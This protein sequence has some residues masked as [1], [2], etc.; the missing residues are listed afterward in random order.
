MLL[1][2]AVPLTI[3]I[4]VASQGITQT[5][6]VVT[7][8]DVER[9]MK[10]LSNWGRWGKEDQLGTLNLITPAK[11]QA[12]ARLVRDGVTVSLSSHCPCAFRSR[13]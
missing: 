8:A 7:A 4:F 13:D 11:R 6:R 5:R 2:R 9:W 1:S 3:L 12:A 10:D